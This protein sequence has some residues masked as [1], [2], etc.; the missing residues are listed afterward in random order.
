MRPLHP[1]SALTPRARRAA[2]AAARLL[3]RSLRLALLAAA[4]AVPLLLPI[5]AAAQAPPG[6]LLDGVVSTYQDLAGTWLDRIV[7]LAERTF[8]LLAVL[9]IAISGIAWALRG[10]DLDT[11]AVALLR[12]TIVLGFLY[13]LL[14]LFPLWI[15]AIPSGFEVAGQT[16]SATAAVNPSQILDLGTTIGAKMLLAFD[17]LDLLVNP[18]GALLGVLVVFCVVLAFG[19]IAAQVCLTLV[20]TFIVLS[21]GAL[22]LGFGAFRATVSLTEG[23]IAYA[24]QVGTRIYLLYLLLSAGTALAQQWAAI[25]FTPVDL[26]LTSLA[27]LFQVLCGAIVFCLLVWILPRSISARLVSGLNLRLGDAL[28]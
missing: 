11:I 23:Y 12:K 1:T 22:F 15:P 20:E 13:S 19:L 16:A 4:L 21:A 8:G 18:V 10:A 25:D 28:R 7:P 2:A 27:P 6:N 26:E 3:H 14:L 24:F 5:A 17:A 9:E